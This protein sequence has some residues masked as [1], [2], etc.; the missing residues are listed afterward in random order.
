MS[1]EAR[2]ESPLEIRRKAIL[3]ELGELVAERRKERGWGPTELA[4]KFEEFQGPSRWQEYKGVWALEH[5][6]ASVDLED[7]Q[8]IAD[9]FGDPVEAYLAPLLPRGL[10]LPPEEARAKV[11]LAYRDFLD[12]E[13]ARV[14]TQ[15]SK[16]VDDPSFI[17][18]V[19][20]LI[21]LSTSRRAVVRDV[22]RGL[23][24]NEQE[25]R[26]MRRTPAVSPDMRPV[27]ESAA[28]EAPTDVLDG[29]EIARRNDIEGVRA[30]LR[31]M[32][33]EY[34]EFQRWRASQESGKGGPKTKR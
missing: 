9:V 2:P 20:W 13:V 31:A 17:Q 30:R 12:R 3:T 4:G 23:R 25:D 21:E 33:P 16:T 24:R 8:V 22:V 18:L 26:Y 29:D 10:P 1:K 32:D 28:P 19:G 15:L 34:A 5:G 14:T 11:A 7:I 27:G 6:K